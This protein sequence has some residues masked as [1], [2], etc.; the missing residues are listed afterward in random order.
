MF[1]QLPEGMTVASDEYGLLIKIS[2]ES[3]NDADM[4]VC[5][6]NDDLSI[7]IRQ[8]KNGGMALL[9]PDEIGGAERFI[10][11]KSENISVRRFL[12]ALYSFCG[13]KELDKLLFDT[14]ILNNRKIS[15]LSAVK[16]LD[17]FNYF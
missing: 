2:D 5:L 16:M 4:T 14:M 15:R 17:T 9:Y 13:V 10:A 1:I 6:E 7:G 12:S 8:S 11:Y 3:I